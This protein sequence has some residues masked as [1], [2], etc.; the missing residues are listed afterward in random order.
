MPAP[1]RRFHHWLARSSR[2]FWRSRRICSSETSI[3]NGVGSI[4]LVPALE[5][6]E[7]NGEAEC[8][9]EIQTAA[10]NG[11]P[12]AFRII[13]VFPKTEEDKKYH[14]TADQNFVSGQEFHLVINP[15]ARMQSGRAD[16]RDTHK[17]R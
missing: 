1:R 4:L 6:F 5:V 7:I 13:F 12:F 10:P 16:F 8:N 9:D 15:R 3:K 11:P 14:G 2:A 17:Q